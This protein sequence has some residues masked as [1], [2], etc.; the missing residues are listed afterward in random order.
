MPI[1]RFLEISRFLHFSDASVETNPKDKLIKIRPVIRYFET[2]F[3]KTYQPEPHISLDESLMK[4]R[5]RL[6]YIQF[7]LKKRASFGVK[8]YKICEVNSGYCSVF[9]IYVGEDKVSDEF[10][11]SESVVLDLMQPFY[12]LGYTVF[13]DN[14]YVSPLLFV[15]L[16]KRDT[17]AIGTALKTRVDIPID[18]KNATLEKNE[19]IYRSSHGVLATMWQDNKDVIVLSTYHTDVSF[20]NSRTRKRKHGIEEEVVKPKLITDYNNGMFGVDRIDQRLASFP[21][22]RRTVKAYKKIFFYLFDLAI[23]NAFAIYNKVKVARPSEKR[24]FTDFRVNLAEQMLSRVQLPARTS[25]GRVALGLDP[26]RLQ[27]KSWAHF[28]VAIPS[29]GDKKN[30][31]KRCKVCSSRGLRSETKWL[32][33]RCQV[34]LHL[35]KDCFK[36][37][38]SRL[39]Y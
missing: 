13:L 24:H 17:H 3:L 26:L 21:I 22:M 10:L 9:K 27:A 37:Y 25:P 39:H 7:N 2:K 32:C 12:N 8:V 14:W 29:R 33:E 31:C 1:A 30:P 38:H 16:L 18:F 35:D 28:P 4:M 19:A 15:E 5:S 23:F 36:V 20:E 6:S 11:A 34:P